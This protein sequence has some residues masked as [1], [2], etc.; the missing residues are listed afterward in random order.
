MAGPI[1]GKLA[2]LWS[3]AGSATEIT[4]QACEN[5]SGDIYHV[6]DPTKRYLDPHTTILVYDDDVLQTSGYTIWGGCQIR[7][8]AAPTT[9]I[10]VS[11]KYYTPAEVT[12]VTDWELSLSSEVYDS[13]AIGATARAKI[14]SGVLDWTGSFNRYYE[15]NTWQAK[16][17]DNST[18][19][20]IRCFS[21]QSAGYCWTGWVALTGQTQG[22][23]VGGLE[24]ESVQFEGDGYAAYTTDET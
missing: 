12:L 23:S 1:T 16:A 18:K 20:I 4:K 2:E 9:P 3:S 5:V 6:T 17:A 8:D 22:V 7:F 10:T 19:R 15:D 13:T 14:P 24:T 11:G 21:D